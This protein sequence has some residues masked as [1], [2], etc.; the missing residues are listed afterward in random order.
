[1][2]Q[3]IE[4]FNDWILNY[5]QETT[6]LFGEFNRLSGQQKA[7]FIITEEYF[8]GD[9]FFPTFAFEHLMAVSN[10]LIPNE[11]YE[12][13]FI[14]RKDGKDIRVTFTFDTREIN[15][16]EGD[17]EFINFPQPDLPQTFPLGF[18]AGDWYGQGVSRRNARIFLSFPLA[19]S[20]PLQTELVVVPEDIKMTNVYKFNTTD[21]VTFR[22]AIWRRG[23]FCGRRTRA[24]DRSIID[25][26]IEGRTC[27]ALFSTSTY[28]GVT[29]TFDGPKVFTT[30]L[31]SIGQVNQPNIWTP[32]INNDEFWAQYYHA[33]IGLCYFQDHTW[34]PI[35]WINE[36]ITKEEEERKEKEGKYFDNSNNIAFL[37]YVHFNPIAKLESDFS[38][39]LSKGDIN[40]V[41]KRCVESC[42]NEKIIRRLR[43]Y[44]LKLKD[45]PANADDLQALAVITSSTFVVK[46]RLGV[47]RLYG[48]KGNGE[49]YSRQIRILSINGHAADIKF[50]EEPENFDRIIEV[51]F[52]PTDMD[53][54]IKL[55]K[56]ADVFY[57]GPSGVKVVEDGQIILYREKQLMDELRKIQAIYG[58]N[59]NLS[60][61]GSPFG[62][63]SDIWKR[64]NGFKSTN[65]NFLQNWKAATNQPIQWQ[66][67]EA[68]ELNVF[69][70]SQAYPSCPYTL[71]SDIYEQ[72]GLPDNFNEPIANP[73]MDILNYNGLTYYEIDINDMS[74]LAKIM[75]R[76]LEKEGIQLFARMNFEIVE[77]I[78]LGHIKN[79][80][81]LYTVLTGNTKTDIRKIRE[82]NRCYTSAKTQYSSSK[83]I[84]ERSTPYYII[85][86]YI[87]KLVPNEERN[88]KRIY[89]NDKYD[90][91]TLSDELG[92]KLINTFKIDDYTVLEYMND[93]ENRCQHIYAS[94]MGYTN[95]AMLRELSKYEWSDIQFIKVDSFGIKRIAEIKTNCPK[96]TDLDYIKHMNTK[97]PGS[98][99]MTEVYK[100]AQVMKDKPMLVLPDITNAKDESI[101]DL[102]AGSNFTILHGSAGVGKTYRALELFQNSRVICLC[103][104][105]VLKDSSKDKFES[106][107]IKISAMTYHFALLPKMIG[108]ISAAKAFDHARVKVPRNCFIYLPEI[109]K[110][111]KEHVELLIP[112][113]L[114]EHGCRIIADGDRYQMMPFGGTN[115]W[116]WLDKHATFI[117]MNEKDWRSKEPILS[118]LKDQLRQ[119]GNYQNIGTLK[120][121]KWNSDMRDLTNGT[122]IND[123]WTPDIYTEEQFKNDWKP[124]PYNTMKE[125]L[126]LVHPYDYVYVITRMKRDEL[127]ETLLKVFTEKYPTLLIRH[128]YSN[129]ARS[130]SGK[131]VYCKGKSEDKMLRLNLA[132]TYASCQGATAEDIIIDGVTHRPKIW[133]VNDCL[134]CAAAENA[135]YTAVTR[136]QYL[137]QVMLVKL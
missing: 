39:Q 92:T 47:E 79:I 40:C 13:I 23:S 22:A 97:T 124:V 83:E 109:G 54:T 3:T 52:D 136:A 5:G 33:V 65:K 115:P 43:D 103:P 37:L 90:V 66:H 76:C 110:W 94:I 122:I 60:Y 111:P 81:L 87:G 119:H 49:Y 80:K 7:A 20:E 63:E 134:Q 46:D 105:H 9:Q 59:L 112:F 128:I 17:G 125:F 137:E 73:S 36:E 86:N 69:D 113:L 72:Y 26:L 78:K 108:G 16:K 21:V 55:I 127:N 71:C 1:M 104:T 19:S 56:T 118:I 100:P 2:F 89:S 99:R 45:R 11:D 126:D 131:V 117:E 32:S 38:I 129:W 133:L 8:E 77:F 84:Y 58:E 27:N 135:I 30:K 57:P 29:P 85:R 6:S 14:G 96:P 123:I 53:E 91:M 10:A 61:Y 41:I 15:I 114:G 93:G 42:S 35:N 28:R 120:G 31:N 12:D 18:T 62:Y 98:W 51:D 116:H 121:M 107:D 74:M 75:H 25:D 68:K 102:F 44:Q 70:I 24:P 48:K 4:E 95:C 34:N 88:P 82:C 50:S 130:K 67:K 132:S 64:D 101:K 106:K